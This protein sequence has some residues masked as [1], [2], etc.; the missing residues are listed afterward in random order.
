MFRIEGECT[1]LKFTS[2][3]TFN[4]ATNILTKVGPVLREKEFLRNIINTSTNCIL[5]CKGW[6]KRLTLSWSTIQITIISMIPV[7]VCFPTDTGNEKEK[8][9]NKGLHFKTCL[10][11][12]EKIIIHNNNN[13]KPGH[14]VRN[15][16]KANLNPHL[17]KP[18]TN[19]T[20]LNLRWISG[21][22]HAI[23]I[24]EAK[25]KAL[26]LG[27]ADLIHSSERA[28][29]GAWGNKRCTK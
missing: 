25:V 5:G 2:N 1:I 10:H 22:S 24:C 6:T 16:S 4:P 14:F 12:E 20:Y 18:Q 15:F 3:N 8:G 9:V 19:P 28:C 23:Y 27:I 7:T 11:Y 17:H 21:A 26:W 13:N 29:V